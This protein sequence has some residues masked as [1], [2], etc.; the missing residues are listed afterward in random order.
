MFRAS[1]TTILPDNLA[2]MPPIKDN[3]RSGTMT[4]FES[5]VRLGDYVEEELFNDEGRLFPVGTKVIVEVLA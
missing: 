1:I 5:G 2:Q 3:F 4:S